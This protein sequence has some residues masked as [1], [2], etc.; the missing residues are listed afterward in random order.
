MIEQL[1]LTGCDKLTDVALQLMTD[2]V[3]YKV[4][5]CDSIRVLDLT[6]CR[7]MSLNGILKFLPECGVLE[8]LNLSALPGVDDEFIHRL[9]LAVPTILKLAILI[10]PD[11]SFGL[12]I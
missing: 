7:S 12:V 2:P 5:L 9:C 10:Y 3:P 11:L 4:P 8:D 1:N 6:S